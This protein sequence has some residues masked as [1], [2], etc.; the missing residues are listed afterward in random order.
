VPRLVEASDN[1][2]IGAHVVREKV[3]SPDHVR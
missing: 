1:I 3:V 2:F